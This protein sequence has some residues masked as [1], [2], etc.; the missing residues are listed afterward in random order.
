MTLDDICGATMLN[1]VGN[2]RTFRTKSRWSVSLAVVAAS[3][4][5]TAPPIS[6]QTKPIEGD[7]AAGRD[8]AL[9]ACTGCHVVEPN[10]PFKPLYPGPPP[11]LPTSRTSQTGLTSQRLPCSNVW[12]RW[13]QSQTIHI[14]PTCCCRAAK[15]ATSSPSFSL[16][17]ISRRRLRNK[18]RFAETRR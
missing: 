3:T 1:G 11:S 12:T 15:C 14:C 16:Y 7:I 10:Q 4:A 9:L 2:S 13:R 5:W 18:V 8:M 17:A 6:A